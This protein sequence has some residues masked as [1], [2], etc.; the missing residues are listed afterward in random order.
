MSGIQI[1]TAEKLD[2]RKTFAVGLGLFAGLSHDIVPQ[3]YSNVPAFLNPITGSSLSLAVVVAVAL[4]QL[5]GWKPKAQK[6][7]N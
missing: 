4:N 3:V 5:L 2:Y 7:V 6:Q 1:I